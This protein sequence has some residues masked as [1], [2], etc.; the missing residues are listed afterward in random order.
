[1]CS[2][3]VLLGLGSSA[4]LYR[5]GSARAWGSAVTCTWSHGGQ[6]SILGQAD[7]QTHIR[8]HHT[9][10]FPVWRT[11]NITWEKA[12]HSDFQIQFLELVWSRS[13]ECVCLKYTQGDSSYQSLVKNDMLELHDIRKESVSKLQS[14]VKMLYGTIL[15]VTYFII[16][17]SNKPS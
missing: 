4:P 16:I 7:S 12:K 17:N 10:C 5:W 8:S 1:M 6:D 2:Q 13:Q 9:R 14:A 3:V 11:G 15:R